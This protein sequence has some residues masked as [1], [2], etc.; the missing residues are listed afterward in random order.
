MGFRTKIFIILGIFTLA[1]TVH[2]VLSFVLARSMGE[3]LSQSS[4]TTIDRL[5]DLIEASQKEKAELYLVK[6]VASIRSLLEKIEREAL[7]L[8]DFYLTQ[9][10]LARLSEND[11]KAAMREI[12][13]YSRN[14]MATEDLAVNGFGASFE[15][16]MFS[17]WQKYY[18]PY[19]YKEGD[20]F[21][22]SHGVTLDESDTTGSSEEKNFLAEFEEEY[23]TTSV[24]KDHDRAILL[25]K[26][27]EWTYPYVDT[28]SKVPVVSATVPISDSSR[29]VGVV[30]IDLALE[31][32][33]AINAEL[34][35]HVPGSLTLVSNFNSG[36]V[37]V[38]S[39]LPNYEPKEVPDS[40][41]PSKTAFTTVNLNAYP[42]G[43]FINSLLKG[44]GPGDVKVAS[45]N[46]DG[47]DYLAVGSNVNGLL[48]FALMIPYEQIYKDVYSAREIGDELIEVQTRDVRI[49][50]FESI[51]AMVV[52]AVV[53]L[54]SIVFII[55]TTGVLQNVGDMLHSQAEGVATMSERMQQLSTK[56]EEEGRHQLDSLT[57]ASTAIKDISSKLTG[58]AQTTKN[59]G[60]AMDRASSEVSVGSGTVSGMRSAMDAISQASLEVANILGDIEAI[61]FQTN[62]LALNASVEA[63][64]AGEAGQGFAVVAEEVRNL[65]GATKD[66]A[67]KTSHLLDQALQRA[68]KGQVAADDLFESFKGIETGV[69]E[70]AD[71]I[72]AVNQA[73]SEQ[74]FAVGDVSRSVDELNE[75]IKLRRD[76][77]NQTRNNSGELSYQAIAL[78]DTCSKLLSI[79]EGNSGYRA[80]IE[81]VED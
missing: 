18:L 43:Q 52:L 8:A 78:F 27:V 3:K 67:Q 12:E 70:A 72:H 41:D 22:F 40:Q 76:V 2:V 20:G 46:I 53:L 81:K 15:A 23:Y 63:A 51:V 30:F 49:I 21:S 50:S 57:D 56:L 17:P 9:M 31:Q 16:S 1:V 38:Q 13:K 37:I 19:I 69:L 58:T 75:K 36:E 28:I 77:V 59:C 64:R 33:A 32:L 42:E 44:L 4:H 11:T 54:V 68:K 73:T 71:M 65:A 10:D 66:A 39:G 48:G 7:Y 5:T 25:P 29:V 26:D 6:D 80:K 14:I 35:S 62:L 60:Q 61:A 34:A 24:P 79:L 45:R 47:R 55:K 74:S